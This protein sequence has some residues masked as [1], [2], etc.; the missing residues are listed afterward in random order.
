MAQYETSK[1][2]RIVRKN[3]N[4]VSFFTAVWYNIDIKERLEEVVAMKIIITTKNSNASD[5]LKESIDK[6]LGKLGKY[7][8]DEIN[9]NV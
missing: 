6:N 9:A 3:K 1:V 5:A 8:S 7:F 2:L 4:T